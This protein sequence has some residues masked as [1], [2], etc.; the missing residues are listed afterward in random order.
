MKNKKVTDLVTCAFTTYNSS[1]SIERAITSA[2]SQDYKYIEIIVVDDSSTDNTLK[3]LLDL[4]NNSPYPFRIISNKINMGV[5]YSRDLLIKESKGEFIAFFDDDDFSYKNR[6]SNQ[7]KK[8]KNFEKES[9]ENNIN[10]HKSPICY[11]N[12]YLISRKRKI[13]IKSI[14]SDFRKISSKKTSYALLSCGS[15]PIN[16]RPGS[17]ATCVLCA[18]LKTLRLLGGFNHQLRRF[19]DL[20]IAVRAAINN[21]SMISTDSILLDQ[22]VTYGEEKKDSLKYELLLIALNRKQ[23]NKRQYIF[24]NNFIHFKNYCFSMMP[25][26]IVKYF[27][28]LSVGNPIFFLKKLISSL[29]TILISLKYNNFFK[30]N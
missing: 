23:L 10:Y 5:G 30:E 18:R 9:I 26:L 14:F 8:I 24:A 7:L 6:I 27:I 12:R 21:I 17:T 3:I 22:Y 4:A 25:L 16:A 29:R 20:D 2:F 13:L 28:K 15:F 1:D 11:C 19:E